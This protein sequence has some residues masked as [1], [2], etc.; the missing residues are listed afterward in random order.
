MPRLIKALLG[1]S[2]ALPFI[3][4]AHS[5]VIAFACDPLLGD[6]DC[7]TLEG[8]QDAE[9]RYVAAL[10]ALAG[11]DQIIESFEGPDWDASAAGPVADVFSRN[12]LWKP[13]S[14]STTA[15]LRTTINGPYDGLRKM[16]TYDFTSPTL[17]VLPDSFEISALGFQLLGAGGWFDGSGA[18]LALYIDD[19]VNMVDFTGEQR[20]LTTT[21]KFLGFIEDAGFSR[22]TV[23]LSDEV[24]NETEIYFSDKFT[25]GAPTGSFI[26]ID[27]DLD[28]LPDALD[29]CPSIPNAD[30]ADL[31]GDGIGDACDDDIDGDGVLNIDDAFP[32]YP[33]ESVDTDGDGIGNNADAD[34]D[35]DGVLD[36]NDAFP[37]DPTESVDTDG[38]GIGN[39]ADLDDDGD[40]VLDVDDAFPLDPSESIDTDGDGIGNNADPDD[41]GDGVL[42]VDDAF[43]LDPL[44]SSDLDN[45]GIGDNSDNC[46]ITPNPDQTD[47][48]SDGIGDACENLTD[49]DGD[50]IPNDWEIT[51]NLDPLDPSDASLDLDADGLTNLQEFQLGTNPSNADTDNDGLDDGTEIAEGLNPLDGTDCPDYFCN[52]GFGSWRHAITPV[53]Q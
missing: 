8:H 13:N 28:G 18:K 23:T 14:T 19:N 52:Q 48:D 20:S 39:N 34:D 33:T 5:A 40:G 10:N 31:D 51:N 47:S 3:N 25:F 24:G 36:V 15:A 45:D 42:D 53:T 38:D 12:L 11:T 41:D 50:G 1:L 4:S 37:L 7:A 6:R 17:H 32:S 27:S 22:L 43:P 44:E 26:V 9:A 2:I 35:N 30:Q 49:V 16:Y 46:P 29:N 21:W